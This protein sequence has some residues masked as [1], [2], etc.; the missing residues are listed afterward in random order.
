MNVPLENVL[1]TRVTGGHRA[2][3]HTR[4]VLIA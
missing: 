2:G 3:S 1:G 4:R